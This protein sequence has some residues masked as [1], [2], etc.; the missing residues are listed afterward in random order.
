MSSMNATWIWISIKIV[1]DLQNSIHLYGVFLQWLLNLIGWNFNK[2]FFIER[3]LKSH[4]HNLIPMSLKESLW[5]LNKFP[6][7][8]A[9]QH[10]TFHFL[11]SYVGNVDLRACQTINL[12]II[13][14]PHGN[15]FS[16]Q[17]SGMK[18]RSSH[19]FSQ[20]KC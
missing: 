17:S 9:W 1:P 19:G 20:V 12:L 2:F 13:T 18:E 8:S 7:V 6:G 14:F 15:K 16:H 11:T 4:T 5:P 3:K 10:S